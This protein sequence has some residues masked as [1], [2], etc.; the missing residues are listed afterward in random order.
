MTLDFGGWGRGREPAVVGWPR[1]VLSETGGTERDGAGSGGGERGR[2]LFW[3]D[4]VRSTNAD[5][6]MPPRKGTLE[7][8][9]FV[10]GKVEGSSSDKSQLQ[11]AATRISGVRRIEV[12]RVLEPGAILADDSSLALKHDSAGKGQGS[13]G[14]SWNGLSAATRRNA[15]GDL[16]SKLGHEDPNT[17][18]SKR[19]MNGSLA[20]SP[21]GALKLPLSIL[22]A[23]Q[24]PLAAVESRAPA[25]F[26]VGWSSMAL[27]GASTAA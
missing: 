9:S 8:A 10:A 27:E 2:T 4:R 6:S 5:C 25:R 11:R 12:G 24:R 16:P 20:H 1:L 23:L 22:M 14:F 15:R 13:G 26:D 17:A 19:R 3:G 21:R 7:G 18:W